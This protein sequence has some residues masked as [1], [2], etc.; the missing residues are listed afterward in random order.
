MDT[1]QY[2]TLKSITTFERGKNSLNQTSAS[3]HSL[4][5]C[6]MVF[7]SDSRPQ[8]DNVLWETMTRLVMTH[9]LSEWRLKISLVGCTIR[10]STDT[11]E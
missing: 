3:D 6:V 4:N 2:S 10:E 11:V 8:R 5:L 1:V 7:S 9:I